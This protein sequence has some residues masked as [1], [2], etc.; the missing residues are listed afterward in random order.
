MHLTPQEIRDIRGKRTR[1]EFALLLAVTEQTVYRWEC[2]K[3]E[4][5]SRLRTAIHALKTQGEDNAAI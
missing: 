4:P 3:V 5:R 2:G 1:I